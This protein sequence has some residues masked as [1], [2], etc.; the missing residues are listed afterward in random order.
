MNLKRH[1]L[2]CVIYQRRLI[3]HDIL[4]SKM[5]NYGIRGL[6]N[7]WLKHYLSG[8]QQYVDIDGVTSNKGQIQIGV[9]QGSIVGP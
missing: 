9:P 1:W 6:A 3:D 8:R 2:Y 7:D 4:L 5:N